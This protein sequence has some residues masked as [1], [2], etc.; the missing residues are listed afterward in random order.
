MRRLR[1]LAVDDEATSLLILKSLLGKLFPD[2]KLDVTSDPQEALRL[3]EK[4]PYD[5]VLTDMMMPKISG[6]DVIRHIRESGVKTSVVLITAASSVGDAV[7]AMRLGA[8]DYIEKPVNPDL[9]LEKVKAL[10]SRFNVSDEA[11]D[12]VEGA[13]QVEMEAA[14][15][16]VE[17]QQRLAECQEVLD[18]CLGCCEEN[19]PFS[20]ELKESIRR[21]SC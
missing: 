15:T 19:R 13:H 9:L 5:L 1:I 11:S 2:D 14:N 10:R 3:Q 4:L 6:L 12:K 8:E 7:E 16:V 17:L 18:Q 20:E 21:V